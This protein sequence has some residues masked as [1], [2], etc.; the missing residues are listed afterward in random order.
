MGWK[1]KWLYDHVL[2]F[3]IYPR[4]YFYALQILTDGQ[5]LPP[6]YLALW[7]MTN[8]I[9]PWNYTH[10]M[11]PEGSRCFTH[12]LVA[13]QNISYNC[14][15]LC[16]PSVTFSKSKKHKSPYYCGTT[17]N[18]FHVTTHFYCPKTLKIAI[19]LGNSSVNSK[20][21]LADLGDFHSSITIFLHPK[22]DVAVLFLWIWS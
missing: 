12:S 19:C 18:I 22:Y 9:T 1:F 8:V 14:E 15:I 6:F 10:M 17:G 16:F 5:V 4:V 2:I 13:V 7:I 21:L 3:Y 11:S 20:V